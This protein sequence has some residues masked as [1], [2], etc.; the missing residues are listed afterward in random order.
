MLAR[1]MGL[2]TI[3][4]ADVHD[5]M[6]REPIL[7]LDVNARRSWLTARVPGARHLDPVGYTESDLPAD[8]DAMLVF[9]CSNPLCSK[10]PR[11][12]RR[13]IRMGYRNVQVMA[14]GISGWLNA[15]LPT[16][17]GEA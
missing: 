8:R 7:V 16:D 6:E 1:L 14:A 13:A 12:A 15:A 2:S 17:S 5:R 9:Y 3:S 11:A 10:A 4:P